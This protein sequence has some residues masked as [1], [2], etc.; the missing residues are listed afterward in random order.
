MPDE[1]NTSSGTELAQRGGRGGF[2]GGGPGGFP[3]RGPRGGFP[4][5]RFPRGGFP[6]RRFPRRFPVR[7]RFPRF[8]FL[9][10]GFPT[11]RCYWTDQF[12]RCCDQ[13]GRCC[14]RYGRCSYN[15]RYADN[16]LAM[17]PS[18]SGGWYGAPG[19][20]DMIPDYDDMMDY[21]MDDMD[22]MD[23]DY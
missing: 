6:G 9:P 22:D 2:P 8:F 19:N 11:G 18:Q 7:Q 17:G 1:M 16:R 15:D 23:D 21:D 20:W 10:I 13:F 5:R 3:G 12:G 4:G 14:D